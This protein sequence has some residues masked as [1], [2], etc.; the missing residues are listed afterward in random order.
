MICDQDRTKHINYT[1]QIYMSY[2]IILSLCCFLLLGTQ[3]T[4]AQVND[5]I[6][7]DEVIDEQI[8]NKKTNKKGAKKTP[9]LDEEGKPISPVKNMFVGTDFSIFFNGRTF[10]IGLSPYIGY[11]LA[12]VIALG[13]GGVYE[14]AFDSYYRLSNNVFGGRVFARIRPFVNVRT[15][16]NIYAHLEAEYATSRIVDKQNSTSNNRILQQVSAPAVNVG[17]GY[18]TQFGKGFGFTTEILVNVLYFN[19]NIPTLSNA[20]WEYRVGLYYGF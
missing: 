20:P 19:P 15:L 13:V 10:F 6:Y 3:N 11:R 14:Y 2:K 1:R 5:E 16:Q 17:L 8:N 18:T 12:D 9:K 7:D 4:F